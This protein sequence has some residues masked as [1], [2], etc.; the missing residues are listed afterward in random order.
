MHVPC[1]TGTSESKVW[2]TRDRCTCIGYSASPQTTSL[3]Y[4]HTTGNAATPQTPS[5]TSP[6]FRGRL[7]APCRAYPTHDI[8]RGEVSGQVSV[9]GD[10]HLA[11]PFGCEKKG[12][13]RAADQVFF[14]RQSL[15]QDHETQ[16]SLQK[17]W[18]LVLCFMCIIKTAFC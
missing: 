17:V 3:R 1:S 14:V 4:V 6:R 16:T 9:S 18:K 11:F 5:G 10:S 2:Q 7:G 12:E 8:V 15:L 13:F